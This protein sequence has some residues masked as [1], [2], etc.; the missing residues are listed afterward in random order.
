M[1]RKKRILNIFKVISLILLIVLM[2]II[3][4]KG[5]ENKAYLNQ[6]QESLDIETLSPKNKLAL[7][8]GNEVKNLIDDDEEAIPVFKYSSLSN[9]VIE[10]IVGV[11][12]KENAPVKLEDLSYITVTYW[13]FDGKEHIGEMIVHEKLAHEVTDIFK[14]LYEGKFPIEK[15][16][17]IDEYDAKDELSMAD[18]NTSAFCSREVTGQKGVFSNH[19]Y[20]IAIDINP[21]QNPYIKGEIVLPEEG[22]SYLDRSNVRKGMIIKGDVCYN[23]FK[24][25]GWTWGGEWKS[26]KD[27]QHFEKKIKLD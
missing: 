11:S 17:L 8:E 6:N 1:I 24:S 14:E 22:N 18:N 13:G 15:I 5:K 9:E 26:L 16:K 2:S 27:Y 4:I 7:D 21:I 20:G 25:R 10:K 12:W 23:A 3:E 19:S